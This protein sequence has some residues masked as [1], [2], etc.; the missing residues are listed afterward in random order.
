MKRSLVRI[1]V[2]T[3][4]LAWAA[5]VHALPAPSLMRGPSQVQ[6]KPLATELPGNGAGVIGVGP[7]GV[8]YSW[9][10]SAIVCWKPGATPDQPPKYLYD[11]ELKNQPFGPLWAGMSPDR[12]HVVAARKQGFGLLIVQLSC[13]QAAPPDQPLLLDPKDE[14][15]L[16]FL[17]GP[18]LGKSP[19]IT[20]T[21][22]GQPCFPMG[23]TIKC[24]GPDKQVVRSLRAQD[25][26]PVLDL[27]PQ[28]AQS[29]WTKYPSDATQLTPPQETWRIDAFTMTPDGRLF[30]LISLT[31][32]R[33]SADYPSPRLVRWL[34][35]QT[36][37]GQIRGRSFSIHE[38]HDC[39]VGD[40]ATWTVHNATQINPLLGVDRLI[41]SP[42]RKAVLAWPVTAW[43]LRDKVQADYVFGKPSYGVRIFPDSEAQERRHGYLSLTDAHA[44]VAHGPDGKLLAANLFPGQDGHLQMQVGVDLKYHTYDVVVQDE[45]LDLDGRMASEEAA[46][47]TSDWRIDS[48]GGGSV[49]REEALAGSNPMDPKDDPA[50]DHDTH[51]LLKWRLDAAGQQ[52]P[53]PWG[54]ARSGGTRLEPQ[55][56]CEAGVCWGK[57]GERLLTYDKTLA[58]D[59]HA[60]SSDGTMLL[61]RQPDRLEGLD[62]P[63]GMT[64]PIATLAE[65]EAVLGKGFVEAFPVDRRHVYVRNADQGRVLLVG[66]GPPR[67]VFD[68][69]AVRC[70]S[71]QG[72]A[73]DKDFVSWQYRINWIGYD[74]TLERLVLSITEPENSSGRGWLVGV[75]AS[76]PPNLLVS[77]QEAWGTAVQDFSRDFGH[78][79]TRSLYGMGLPSWLVDTGGELLTD[80]GRRDRYLRTLPSSFEIFGTPVR[81]VFGDTLVQDNY[82][83]VQIPERVDPGELLVA[84]YNDSP[85][86]SEVGTLWHVPERGGKANVFEVPKMQVRGMNVAAD[87]RVCLVTA[88]GSFVQMRPMP[89]SF[90]MPVLQDVDLKVGPVADCDYGPDGRVHLLMTD[91][92]RVLVW[93]GKGEADFETRALPADKKPFQLLVNP[94]G[95][96]R[97]LVQGGPVLGMGRLQDGSIAEVD[98]ETQ[99]LR[100]HGKLVGP[101]LNTRFNSLNLITPQLGPSSWQTLRV[102][103][104]QRPDGLVAAVLYE[105][106]G[107]GKGPTATVLAWDPRT[108]RTGEFAPVMQG[109][110]PVAVAVVPGG[111]ARDPWTG[112]SIVVPPVQMDAGETPG[113]VQPGPAGQS[114][115]GGGCQAGRTAHGAWAW[116][117]LVLGWLVWP[118]S[119]RPARRGFSQYALHALVHRHRLPRRTP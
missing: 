15:F 26:L 6:L 99:R 88:S 37:D 62:V 29:M 92:P 19:V 23:D 27:D 102:R 57:S 105:P 16:E 73:G 22:A 5:V 118:G 84:T 74:T 54:A 31:I 66:D 67:L 18:S 107:A 56:W 119:R 103:L 75:H 9:L 4:V 17:T 46:A 41:Y 97:V 32:L 71:G 98:A 95:T 113:P 63:E 8:V 11:F 101:D 86:G 36:P 52:T 100:I 108:G 60:Q 58:W 38:A 39:E 104:A 21:P 1:L 24:Y 85:L 47:G 80:Y 49:D 7:D 91:P 89:V 77:P 78:C 35:E 109:D 112:G 34:V 110:F 83:V 72:C 42:E 3:L 25:A 76:Q 59:P 43:D 13:D 114:Q 87:R 82:E 33:P 61:L 53:D 14:P 2:A 64:H 90:G 55:P 70:A 40:G 117:G 28:W 48:D 106:T 12:K 94:D 44:A 69:D 50:R 111:V 65:I 30:A 68:L 10:Y 51:K 116:L 81:K 93:N 79:E 20:S 115:D 45:D 96:D